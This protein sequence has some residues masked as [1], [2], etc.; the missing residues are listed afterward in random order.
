MEE[1]DFR[2]PSPPPGGVSDDEPEGNLG[3]SEGPQQVLL[4]LLKDI[5]ELGMELEQQ[6]Q[7]T[8][9]LNDGGSTSEGTK[10]TPTEENTHDEEE[11]NEQEPPLIQR[12]CFLWDLTADPDY[13]E[14]LASLTSSLLG[15]LHTLLLSGPQNT[16]MHEIAAGVLA[17]MVTIPG[18][19]QLVTNQPI[20]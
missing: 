11:E 19:E 9:E 15:L 16:R 3:A 6:Q 17:N 4:H 10:Q 1:Q 2:N 13:A 8:E 18:F 5:A 14:G 12:L 20:M 7:E